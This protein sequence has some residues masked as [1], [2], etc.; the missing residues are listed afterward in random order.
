MNWAYHNMVS[1]Y[2][3]N[4]TL[5]CLSCNLRLLILCF[6]TILPRKWNFQTTDNNMF[7]GDFKSI[8]YIFYIHWISQHSNKYN[9]FSHDDV[10]WGYFKISK[11]F[12]LPFTPIESWIN[13]IQFMI[14][15]LTTHEKYSHNRIALIAFKQT[16][17]YKL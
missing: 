14:E 5:L 6:S 8:L 7:P 11:H 10:I 4:F 1:I 12:P 2:F 15:L 3:I 9:M 17:L 16:Y 13:I